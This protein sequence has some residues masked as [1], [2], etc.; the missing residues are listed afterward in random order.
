MTATQNML[1][2]SVFN[3]KLPAEGPR[4]IPWRP[5]FAT[6]SE[7]EIDLS[8]AVQSTKQIS[9]VQCAYVDNSANTNP[10]EITDL[11]TRQSVS[12][13]GGY[14]AIIPLLSP[15]PP[16]YSAT[17]VAP[18]PVVDVFFL[19]I[20][21]PPGQWPATG[22]A[23]GFTSGGALEVEDVNLEALTLALADAMAIPSG[24][25]TAA[26]GMLYNGATYDRAR[27]NF[28]GTA[29]ASASRAIG[30]TTADVTNYDGTGISLFVNRTA[31]AGNVTVKLQAQ[32]PVSGGWADIPNATTAALAGVGLTMLQVHPDIAPVANVAVAALVPRNI[33]ISATVAGANI[34][35]SVGYQIN[36]N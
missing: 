1:M 20:P 19:N 25:A 18:G 3:A 30:T 33:R 7:V 17:S 12:V 14:Q 16:R 23:F 34:T 21:L 29:L 31:G 28:S 35:Y 22:S 10:V 9:F 2:Q 6:A 8:Y 36:R 5:D 26:Q 13:P 11:N 27:G 24:L 15:N 32:D 4:V